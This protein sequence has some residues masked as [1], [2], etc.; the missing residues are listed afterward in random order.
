MAEAVFVHVPLDEGT[1]NPATCRRG[2]S[3]A[4]VIRANR[5]PG[6]KQ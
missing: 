6:V 4:H 1:A 2:D 3:R 5:W